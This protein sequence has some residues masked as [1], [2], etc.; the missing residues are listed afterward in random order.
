MIRAAVR[1]CG[2]LAWSSLLIAMNA[3]ALVADPTSG[4]TPAKD[5][6]AFCSLLEGPNAQRYRLGQQEQPVARF[7]AAVRDS[8]SRLF[9]GRSVTLLIRTFNGVGGD[10][11]TERDVVRVEG[12]GSTRLFAVAVRPDGSVRD[13]KPAPTSDLLPTYER[14]QLYAAYIYFSELMHDDRTDHRASCAEAY[15]LQLRTAPGLYAEFA[16]ALLVGGTADAH[17][18]KRIRSAYARYVATPQDDPLARELRDTFAR[19]LGPAPPISM[20]YRDVNATT[21]REYILVR[22]GTPERHAY[23]PLYAGDNGADTMGTLPLCLTGDS[24]CARYYDWP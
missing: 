2:A 13:P 12:N 22:L 24:R 7:E 6:L 14:A 8:A 5:Y 19:A 18:T 11:Y 17:L 10:A 9:P 21:H 23:A 15:R 4:P 16:A 1:R 3:S 20:V